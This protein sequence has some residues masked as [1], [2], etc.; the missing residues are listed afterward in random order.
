MKTT[1]KV[2]LF[3][4][5]IFATAISV[6]MRF[7]FAN[8]SIMPAGKQVAP[9]DSILQPPLSP[10]GQLPERT[11][12]SLSVLERSAFLED[13]GKQEALAIFAVMLRAGQEGKGHSK[14]LAIQSVLS[15]A[16]RNQAPGAIFFEQMEVF[17]RDDSNTTFERELVVGA[18]A[19]SRT[20]ES[21]KLLLKL[22]VS[23]QDQ[24]LKRA[25]LQ[26]IKSV[27][28]GGRDEQIAP[29]LES[30]WRD[31]EDSEVLR[32]VSI[33][34]TEIGAPNSIDMLLNAVIQ[35]TTR[36]D[37]R[38]LIARSALEYTTILN[39]NAVPSLKIVLSK[40][41]PETE[42]GKLAADA[43]VR[44]S[45]YAAANALLAWMQSADGESSPLVTNY[46]LRSR[47]PAQLEV[48]DAA[49]DSSI[50]FR[51]EKIRE[52][53]RRGLVEYRRSRGQ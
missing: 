6:L 49:L 47:H 50:Q 16:I 35:N 43:L 40:N 4:V 24:D 27:G 36:D 9:S 34:M 28:V 39:P 1:S 38:A 21:A 42:V 22:A 52:A 10:A 37:T 53:I 19:A 12:A 29:L 45:D 46:I 8:R 32:V 26:G 44:M 11:F 14:Q 5:L 31:T 51:S 2:A 18:L 23:L 17:V 30:V 20:P 48:W 41:P 13:I 3:G 33:A 25:V 7:C 15:N